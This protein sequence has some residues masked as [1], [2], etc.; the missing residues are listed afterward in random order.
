[1]N[2][3]NNDKGGKKNLNIELKDESCNRRQESMSLGS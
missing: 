2:L 1:M 3:M